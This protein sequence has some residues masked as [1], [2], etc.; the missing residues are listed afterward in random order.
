MSI[1]F[2]LSADE[3]PADF[4]KLVADD[5]SFDDRENSLTIEGRLLTPG[6]LQE[7]IDHLTMKN[8]PKALLRLAEDYAREIQADCDRA[9]R[10]ALHREAQ[11]RATQSRAALTIT[12]GLH[13][14]LQAKH[15]AAAMHKG[16]PQKDD[17]GA[18]AEPPPQATIIIKPKKA[19]LQKC[20]PS[21]DSLCNLSSS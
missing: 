3:N 5:I 17:T 14:T 15:E 18:A 21:E 19:S 6:K 9:A 13:S 20:L 11:L 12:R 2:I 1:T 8:A 7:T 4:K 16:A 10:L